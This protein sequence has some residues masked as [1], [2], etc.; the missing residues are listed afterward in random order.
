MEWLKRLAAPV[1]L[2]LVLVGGVTYGILYTSGIVALLPLAAGLALV[3]LSVVL[4]RRGMQSEGARRSARL[5]L[6]AAVSIVV[7]AAILV[8]LQT[9]AVRHTVQYDTTANKRFSLS[10]QTVKILTSLSKEVRVTCFFKEQAAGRRELLDLLEQYANVSHRVTYT[11][12]DPD[13]DPVTARRYKVTSYNTTIV[14]SGGNEEKVMD[15]S[16]EKLTNAVLKVTRDKRKAIYATT[17]H[18]EKSID[19]T[20]G[21]GL[22]ALKQAAE[23]ENYEIKDL[24]TLRD[25]IPS[26]CEILLIAGLEKDLFPEERVMIERYLGRGGKLLALIDPLVELPRVDTLAAEYGIRVTNTVIVDRFG[27]ILA[28]NYYTPIVNKYGAHPITQGFRLATLFPQARALEELDAPQSGVTVTVLAATGPS[29]YAERSIPDVLKGSTKFDEGTDV[30]GPVII[31]LVATKETAAGAGTPAGALPS[32]PGGARVVVFGDSDFA[33]NAYI[34][35]SGNK[36]LIL[37]TISWLAEE[38]DLVAIRAKSPVS[39]PVVLVTRQ[40]RVTFWLPV[41]G[42]SAFFVVL[43]VIVLANRRRSA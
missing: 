27:K 20:E 16:E 28:G 6:N 15:G 11:F 24:F 31:A 4:N 36:D 39:Q 13:K 21:A 14:E 12:I 1:G 26:D 43:G 2:A 33:S 37:N 7:L 35:L 38:A 29:A 34:G 30:E 41:V 10:S 9:L 23:A 3:A 8:F 22:A 32:G 17:G 5:G 40:G 19:D 25:S 42:M 18:G